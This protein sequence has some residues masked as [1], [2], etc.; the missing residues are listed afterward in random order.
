[1]TRRWHLSSRVWVI[2]GLLLVLAAGVGGIIAQNRAA[3]I[4]RVVFQINSDDQGPM[5]HA[6][7]NSINLVTQYREK[8]ESILRS[9]FA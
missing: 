6:V 7:S 8:H 3:G 1:M 2:V 5:K 4:H 9:D